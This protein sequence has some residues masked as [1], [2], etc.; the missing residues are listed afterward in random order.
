MSPG[1]KLLAL[2]S[3]QNE[4][5]TVYGANY[6]RIG[7]A[8]ASFFPDGVTLKSPEDFTR[9]H[10][11]TMIIAK[12][13]RYAFNFSGEPHTDSLNDLS[14]Y[15]AILSMVEDERSNK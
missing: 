2:A 5:D 12:A 4:R 15:A 6:T 14:V 9:Y 3:L 7:Q 1:D 13:G 11:L 8:M 10:L